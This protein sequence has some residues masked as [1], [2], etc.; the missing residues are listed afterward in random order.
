MPPALTPG[1]PGKRV[2]AWLRAVAMSSLLA[3]GGVYALASF[4]WC[5]D[6]SYQPPEVERAQTASGSLRA[7]ASRVAMKP[8]FPV[9][10]AGYGPP[11]PTATAARAELNARALVLEAGGL[12]L[13]LVT[14]DLLL[15]PRATVEALRQRA[16]ALGLAELWVVATHA[17][18]SF[19]GYEDR[20]V[21]ML[22]G[23]GR[24]RPESLAA[25][26][27]AGMKALEEAAARLA[28]ASLA[29]GGRM[30]E[31]KNLPRS[32]ERADARLARVEL[33]SESGARLA[34]LALFA[35]HP[36]LVPRGHDQLDPD[37]PGAL[38]SSEETRS[39][40]VTLVLPGAVGNASAN[41]A[42]G[43]SPATYAQGLAEALASTPLTPS[44]GPVRLGFARAWAA[45]PRPDASRLV[46]ALSRRA[47]E[48]FLCQS[49]PRRA[50]VGLLRLGPYTWVAVP[51]EPTYEAGLILETA[52][53]AGATVGLAN[54]YLGYV[55]G[56]Q[57]VKAN[58]GEAHRQYFGPQLVELLAGAAEAARA[59]LD[60]P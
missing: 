5:G 45:L 4:N 11:R 36:T 13:G 12:K 58:T 47:G 41:R 18:S 21:A 50:E 42:A 9:V 14:F 40:G 6:W 2:L 38:A 8:P 53:G 30:L 37:W 60:R 28:P 46:P 39:G 35:A 49:A 24:H 56:A 19:G 52:S 1:R 59:A 44:P 48:N 27:S 7:G 26:S 29:G 22:A 10:V 55:E 43:D 15:I 31:E 3:F 16:A 17:H 20:P 23:T 25:V 57:R 54:G 34:Q 33:T 51:G 32:G